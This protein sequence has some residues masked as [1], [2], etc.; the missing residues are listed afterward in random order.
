MGVQLWLLPLVGL[1][2]A[3]VWLLTAQFARLIETW[4]F[5]RRRRRL[6]QLTGRVVALTPLGVVLRD[7]NGDHLVVT[8]DRIAIDSLV[9]V[10]G[11]WVRFVDAQG[12]VGSFRALPESTAFRAAS[13]SAEPFDVVDR[14]ALVHGA[15][16]SFAA[17]AVV[18]ATTL[19]VRWSA[20]E[21]VS[22]CGLIASSWSFDP[23]VAVLVGATIAIVL[24]GRGLRV[25]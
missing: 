17:I 21:G 23:S 25:S 10:A 1:G 2:A 18:G 12:E 24:V 9:H 19:L 15:R 8:R 6:A 4:L 14:H 22:T 13:I 5:V 20:W 11:D 3:S 16:A 7:A